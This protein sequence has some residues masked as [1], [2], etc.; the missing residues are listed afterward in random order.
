MDLDPELDREDA[1]SLAGVATV[2]ALVAAM[3]GL[4]TCSGCA[5]LAAHPAQTLTGYLLAELVS[6]TE[7]LR[8]LFVGEGG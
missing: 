8:F 7:L 1:A 5:V 2:L 4:M 6:L 3:L